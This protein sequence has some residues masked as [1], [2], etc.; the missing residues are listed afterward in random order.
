MLLFVFSISWVYTRCYFYQRMFP[1]IALLSFTTWKVQQ[2]YFWPNQ[3]LENNNFS[4]KLARN[5][6]LRSEIMRTLFLFSNKQACKISLTYPTF[7]LDS[8][9]RCILLEMFSFLHSFVGTRNL[10]RNKTPLSY[11]NVSEKGKIFWFN[12]PLY[13]SYIILL[14]EK[15]T[16]YL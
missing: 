14:A 8:S 6:M 1:E 13:K 15:H 2:W 11:F 5:W 4:T 7:C 16:E 10:I 12:N 9:F 3:N